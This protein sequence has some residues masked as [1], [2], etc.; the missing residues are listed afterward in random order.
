MNKSLRVTDYLGHILQA[1]ERIARYTV[2][3]DE[4]GF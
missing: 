1:I 4:V 3:M 2:E